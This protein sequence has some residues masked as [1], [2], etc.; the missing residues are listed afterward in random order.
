M[1]GEQMAMG[2]PIRATSQVAAGE[3]VHASASVTAL[4]GQSP[5]DVDPTLPIRA[6]VPGDGQHW[7]PNATRSNKTRQPMPTQTL[8][9]G[10]GCWNKHKPSVSQT[11]GR[12]CNKCK[13]EDL[14]EERR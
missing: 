11:E 5:S 2:G 14:Q 12:Y 3:K 10:E 6:S 4:R 7:P 9:Q 1:E 8:P 13:S